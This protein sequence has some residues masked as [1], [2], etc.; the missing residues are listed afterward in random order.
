MD[1]SYLFMK[2]IM[3]CLGMFCFSAEQTLKQPFSC[4]KVICIYIVH[5]S[6]SV[7]HRELKCFCFSSYVLW[8]AVGLLMKMLV[9][10]FKTAVYCSCLRTTA[11]VA[12]NFSLSCIENLDRFLLLNVHSK[13]IPSNLQTKNYSQQLSTE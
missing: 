2:S 8:E 12:D 6:M 7:L 1:C 9:L 11:V 3:F 5:H 4:K 10:L 13:M